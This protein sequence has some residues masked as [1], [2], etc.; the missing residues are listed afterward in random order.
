MTMVLQGYCRN[1]SVKHAL[2]FPRL[3]RERERE[4]ESRPLERIHYAAPVLHWTQRTIKMIRRNTHRTGSV[5]G[6]VFERAVDFT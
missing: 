4:R 6:V 5:R 1:F 2:E 3:L